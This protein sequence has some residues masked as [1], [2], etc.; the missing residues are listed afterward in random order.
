MGVG[1]GV[2]VGVGVDLFSGGLQAT[3]EIDDPYNGTYFPIYIHYEG[4]ILKKRVTPFYSI[5][6]G[7]AFRLSPTDNN[8]YISVTPLDHPVYKNLGGF[9][10]SIGFGVKLYGK[11]RV[12][13]SWALDLDIKHAQDRYSNYYYNSSGDRIDVSYSSSVLFLLPGIKIDVGF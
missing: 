7:Y 2:G 4:D 5:E 13:A 11:K 8:Y 10:G 3:G 1:A 9:T 12:Y 6:A